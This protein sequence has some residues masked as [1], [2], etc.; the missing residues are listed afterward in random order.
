MASDGLL[1]Q[2]IA[3]FQD[4]A[5]ALAPAAIGA[6]V[7]QAWEKGLSFSQRLMQW[8]IGICVS[9]YVGGGLEAWL[10]LDPF[11][12]DAISFVLA[13]IAFKATPRFIAGG[14]DVIGTLPADLRKRF[15]PEE[16]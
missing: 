12:S 16:D 8:G 1:Q 11:V 4:A 2:I 5:S 13:M 3:G 9:Y 7:G 14:V 10:R 15:L 6:A